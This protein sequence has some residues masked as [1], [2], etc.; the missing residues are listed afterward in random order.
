MAG[1]ALG[2]EYPG[3]IFCSYKIKDGN[4]WHDV[5][6]EIGHNWFP[7]IV[8]SNERRYMWMDEGLNTFINGYASNWFNHGEYGDTTNGQV[9]RMARVLSRSKSPLMTLPAAMGLS[10][11]GQYYYKASL[12]L[13]L[14]R[15]VVIGPDRF[16]YAFKAYINRWKFKHPQPD[17][18]FRTIN[19]AAGEDLNWFWKE[20]FYTTWN[21]DQAVKDVRYVNNNA[22]SGS[23]ITIDNLGKM[24][25]PVTIKVTEQNDHSET[26]KLPV[27]IWQR[28]G[29]WTFK[30]NSTS[31]V[32]SVV[33][34]PQGELPDLDR[35]NNSWEK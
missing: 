17:D 30:Y 27:E 1:V 35:A 32:V 19:N 6:H 25:M 11:Y 8:G 24:V 3:I 26:V 18:F 29:E 20:W 28:G 16:D 23:L 4:L 12:A 31:P 33:I 9:L 7:M 5:T 34:D 21:L 13:N 15:N 22:G 10:D 2:M 14:L